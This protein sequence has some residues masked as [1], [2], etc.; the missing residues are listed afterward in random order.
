MREWEEAGKVG[1]GKTLCSTQSSSQD[2]ITNHR[3]SVLPLFSK[4]KLWPLLYN[5]FEALGEV[6]LAG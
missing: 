2:L 6:I 1:S 5:S 3:V 4:P